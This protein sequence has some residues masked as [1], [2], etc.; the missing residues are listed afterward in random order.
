MPRSQRDSFAPRYELLALSEGGDSVERHS[1]DATSG[2]LSD[3]TTVVRVR[4]GRGETFTDLS[5]MALNEGTIGIDV[6]GSPQTLV[7]FSVEEHGP[8]HYL[9]YYTVDKDGKGVRVNTEPRLAGAV[10]VRSLYLPA[11][12]LP[13]DPDAGALKD[14]GADPPGPAL[15]AQNSPVLYAG[16]RDRNVL[17]VVAWNSWAEVDG[18]QHWTSYNGVAVDP[19]YVWVF[20]K[21]GIACATHASMIKCRQQ[22]SRTPAWVYHDFP[23]PFSAPEVHALNPC[24]DGTLLVAMQGDIYTADYAVD[25]L[26]NRVVTSSWVA[27]GGPAE[28]VGK[29]P[30]PCWPVLESLRANLEAAH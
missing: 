22:K 7:S 8:A 23:A 3:G 14:A 16:V 13:D 20:G 5:A 26:K 19:Y 29:L 21:G 25:K 2:S 15:T 18:P 28:Q 4:D 27:R 11:A 12:P 10:V 1:L 9:N 17:H 24:V 6:G 30:V